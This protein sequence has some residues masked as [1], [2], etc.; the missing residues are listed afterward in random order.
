M[1]REC[2]LVL[3]RQ[4]ASP[5][6]VLI[7]SKLYRQYP[8]HHGAHWAY[9]NDGE[10]QSSGA[11][12]GE[13]HHGREETKETE[14]ADHTEHTGAAAGH[15]RSEKYADGTAGFRAGRSEKDSAA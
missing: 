14:R 8:L 2:R 9:T 13:H 10:P 6:P 4:M 3:K 11:K 5:F 7:F 15:Q 1:K 12:R